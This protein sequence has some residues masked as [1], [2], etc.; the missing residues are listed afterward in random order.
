MGAPCVSEKQ[1]Q[2]VERGSDPI[3]EKPEKEVE[4]SAEV[5]GESADVHGKEE[6]K[7]VERGSDPI[8]E[9]LVASTELSESTTGKESGEASD[10][11]SKI[12]EG[13]EEPSEE[14]SKL[15][16]TGSDPIAD[17]IVPEG[18][19]LTVS[20]PT[21]ARQL[22]SIEEVSPDEISGPAE[23]SVSAATKAAAV[24]GKVSRSQ[25]VEG[26]YSGTFPFKAETKLE[27]LDEPPA[28]LQVTTIVTSSGNLEV[29]TE[30]GEG[31][32]ETQLIYRDDGT[33]EVIQSNLFR[34][35]VSKMGYLSF[36]QK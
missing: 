30:G 21:E 23:E 5:T 25:I 1:P 12:A 13:S 11:L 4:E 20:E 32:I 28:G 36:Y 27:T 6:P 31:L 16:E 8:I 24:A 29:I 7:L 2:I 9:T 18:R 35:N 10:E 14:Q 19:Q 15:V 34:G 17:K 3:V 26:T 33:I 22:E